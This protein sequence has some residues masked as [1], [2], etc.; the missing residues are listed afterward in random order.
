MKR[1]YQ[2]FA[3]VV[4]CAAL[5]APVATR[6]NDDVTL[7]ET[8]SSLIF[9]LF[10]VWLPAFSKEHPGVRIVPSSTGSSAGVAQAMA[11]HVQIG[12]SDAFMTD[13]Q[14]HGNPEIINIPLAISAQTINYNV[15]GLNRAGVHLDGPAVAAI[16]S[17][18]IRFWD[19]APIAALN[20][21]LRLPHRQI[22]P[23]HRSD[24]SGDTFIFTQ[25]LS[26]STPAWDNA[27]GAGNT[28]DWPSVPGALTAIGHPG[29]VKTLRA[30]PYSIA[31]IGVSFQD[32]LRSDDLG[33]AWLKNQDGKFVLPTPQTVTA[34]ASSL[35]PR[36][37]ADERLSLV[38]APGANSYPLVNYEYAI[39]SKTQ[40][41]AATAEAIRSFLF[42][43]IEPCDGNA[44]NMLN[45]VH[46]IPLPEYVRALSYAQIAS[47]K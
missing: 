30:T 37:P 42:W 4:L 40:P 10:R 44:A 43:S 41:N 38:F 46:F 35:G 17:G 1:R 28:V 24:G 11:G 20:P 6:A 7:Q 21:G 39:V 13:A 45:A 12:A 18:D 3:L 32:A 22:I 33:T 47:I 2:S 19:A 5:V 31:Y 29:M 34:A 9:P 8:G 27:A 15:P 16:Y 26:F 25:F 36:T 23:I 14:L